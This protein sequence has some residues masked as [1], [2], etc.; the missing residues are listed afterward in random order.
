M[1]FRSVSQSRYFGQQVNNL[2][3]G[4]AGQNISKFASSSTESSQITTS[5]PYISYVDLAI[6]LNI[7]YQHA[8][9]A[10]QSYFV[11]FPKSADRSA[12][13]FKSWCDSSSSFND[14]FVCDGYRL[15]RDC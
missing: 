12:V 1:L 4:D 2:T 8:V 13:G 14:V 10:F 3:K 15:Y 7:M 9:A 11:K 6:W 5:M